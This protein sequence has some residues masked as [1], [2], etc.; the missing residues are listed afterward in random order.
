MALTSFRIWFKFKKSGEHRS[1]PTTAEIVHCLLDFI[2]N[3]FMRG[4]MSSSCLEEKGI[5]DTQYA[6]DTIC[7]VKKT[8]HKFTMLS[9]IKKQVLNENYIVFFAPVYTYLWIVYE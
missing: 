7:S 1:L 5:C 2:L 3:D 4:K 8:A 6:L 9:V